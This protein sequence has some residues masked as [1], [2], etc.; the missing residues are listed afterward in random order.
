MPDFELF[1]KALRE[2]LSDKLPGKAAQQRMAP[3]L[4]NNTGLTSQAN[5]LVRESAVLICI[6]P[7]NKT[8]NTI[9]IKRTTYDGPHSGQICFPG[10]KREHFDKSI[11][12]TALREAEEEIGIDI[13]AVTILGALSPLHIP[14][15]NY[16]VTP[17]VGIMPKPKSLS[18]DLQEVEYTIT[19]NLQHFKQEDNV[20]VK[21]LNIGSKP[22]TAPFYCVDNEVVWGATAMIISELAELY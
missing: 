17:I 16:M 13:S 10:G 15:S 4:R 8:A 1:V 12:E 9:L 6:Y 5:E 2:N 7:D 21:A 20:S 19:V 14:V 11:V 18:L 22:I 3:S